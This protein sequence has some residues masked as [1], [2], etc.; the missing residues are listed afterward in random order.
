MAVLSTKNLL[1]SSL[2]TPQLKAIMASSQGLTFLSGVATFAALSF[3]RPSQNP[4]VEPYVHYSDG[5]SGF[6]FHPS[7]ERKG[8]MTLL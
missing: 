3:Y 5:F 7:V 2:T 6:D 1:L 8:C 4:A